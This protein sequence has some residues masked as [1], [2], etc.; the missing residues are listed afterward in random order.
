MRYIVDVSEHRAEIIN[1]LLHEGRYKSVGQ[2]IATAIENQIYVEGAEAWP[3]SAAQ[4]EI[5]DDSIGR[6]HRKPARL[7]EAK[8][9]AIT[10]KSHDDSGYP[11]TSTAVNLELPDTK[12]LPPTMAMPK[13]DQL[14]AAL[15]PNDENN[16]WLWG[17]INKIL[18]VKLGSR[19]LYLLLVDSGK[20]IELEQFRNRAAEVAFA[21]GE[22]IREYENKKGKKRDERISAGLPGGDEPFKSKTRYKTHFLGYMRKD[23]K[24]DGAMCGLKLINMHKDDRGRVLI[25]LTEAGVDFA[26]LHNPSM[27]LHDLD[28]SLAKDEVEFYLEHV[29]KN[30]PGEF[31]ALQWLLTTISEGTTAREEIN[32]QLKEKMGQIWKTSDAVISTQRA[33]LSSRASEL[34]LIDTEKSGN[35]AGVIYRLTDRGKTFL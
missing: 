17:Q 6:Q 29:Q 5:V 12:T 26:R 13:Y 27:D 10:K 15:S 14:V 2:F 25:G 28:H 9:L 1:Q 31:Q 33:G 30:V 22:M 4:T 35:G 3:K 16:A 20:S 18:P 34:G 24:L 8:P 7:F 23:G 19:I 21:F 32:R 11:D